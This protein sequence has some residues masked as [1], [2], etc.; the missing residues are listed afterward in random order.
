MIDAMQADFPRLSLGSLR[1]YHANLEQHHHFICEVCGA[2]RDITLP[3]NTNR[4]RVDFFGLC[5][6]CGPDR[7]QRSP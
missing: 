1:R 4:I 7:G 3:L 2:I 6:E 5:I